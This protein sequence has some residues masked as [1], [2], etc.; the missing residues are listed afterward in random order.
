[1]STV[2][3][4][5]NGPGGPRRRVTRG[6]VIALIGSAALLALSLIVCGWGLLALYTDTAPVQQPGVPFAVAPLLVAITHALLAW[7]LWKQAIA[8]LHGRRAP[9]TG[10]MLGTAFGAFLLWCVGGNLAG[11]AVNET[12]LSVYAWLI[13]PVF[14]LTALAFWAV[15]MR[16]VYTDRGVPQWPW[17][18]RG[19]P[20]PDTSWMDGNPWIDGPDTDR[21]PER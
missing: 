14:V 19:E 2:G 8:L 7:S 16:R 13:V 15:L 3:E 11:L 20:G 6:Y 1:M 4:H 18:K 9:H 5:P 12:W 10:W 21:G 17:E